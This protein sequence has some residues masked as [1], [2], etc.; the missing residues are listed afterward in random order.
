MPE[1]PNCPIYPTDNVWHSNI[2]L[3]PVHPMSGTWIANMGGP[4]R[5]LHPDFGGPYGYQLQVTSN[6]TPTTRVSFDY[7]D[8][9][10]D[11]PSPFTANTPVEP[12]SDAH[13][14]MLNRDTCILYELFAAS[15]NGGRPT[16]GSGAVFDL[17][18]HDLRPAGW[19]S[20]DAAGLP[21]WPGVLRYDEVAR[22]LVDHAIRFTAQRTD[23]SYVWPARHQAG[24]ARDP[25]LPPMGARFRLKS[26]FSFAGFSP[27]TQVVLMAMQRYGLILADNGS[28][29]YFQGEV[30]SNWSEQLISEL[31]RIPAGAFEAV[32][33]SSLML[34]ANSGRVPAASQNQALLPGWHSTWQSQSDYLVMSPASVADFWIRFSNSGTETWHRGIWGR[35]ANLGLNGDDKLPYRLGMAADWLWDDR[36]ATTT[37]ATVA[38]GEIAEFR[39]KVRA[40]MTPGTYRLNLRPVID[41]T[42][43]MEDQGVF[44]LIVVR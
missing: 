31:K 10:D 14:F 29:F 12:A 24:A 38:P 22:G 4:S 1:A 30:S 7:A 5:L 25:S 26:S 43:W 2:Q 18:R 9:S 35:Q 16:A 3:M 39:F 21:I 37:A 41:G 15:W 27:Q 44:W 36:I 13:A 23:R 11:V 42:V 19:T 33:A 8:E 6:A 28:N 20:A 17:K 34:D 40:P 32:D